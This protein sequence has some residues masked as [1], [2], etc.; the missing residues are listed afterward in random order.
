MARST[1]LLDATSFI[2]G[3]T[4]AADGG[5]VHCE[6]GRRA[7]SRSDGSGIPDADRHPGAGP[8]AQCAQ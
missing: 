3:N 6:H 8:A 4:V 7:I 5:L 1:M 2:N